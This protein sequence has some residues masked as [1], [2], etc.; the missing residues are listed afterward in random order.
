MLSNLKE[1]EMAAATDLINGGLSMAK[2]CM[3]QILQSPMDLKKI[4]FGT[5]NQKVPMFS[6]KSGQRLHLIKTEMKG[7]LSGSCFLIFS[8]DEVTKIYKACLPEEF[9]TD[10]SEESQDMRMAF[11]TEMD[12]MVAAAV[13]TEFS[14]ILDLEL[15]GDVPSACILDAEEVD[16]YLASESAVFETIVHFKANFHGVELDIAP[17]FIWMFSDQFVDKIKDLV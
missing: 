14:N 15:F 9:I 2:T 8:E 16:E 17:D 5:E 1:N 11:L 6:S 10:N 7:Q 13:V 3:E 4:D 12:N